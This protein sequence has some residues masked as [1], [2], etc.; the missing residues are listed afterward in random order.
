MNR[1]PDAPAFPVDDSELAGLVDLDDALRIEELDATARLAALLAGDRELTPESITADEAFHSAGA[2]RVLRAEA[3]RA[4]ERVPERALVLTDAAIAIV[5]AL[6]QYPPALTAMLRASAWRG[7]AD[8]LRY[9]GRYPE[10]LSALDEAEGAL[11]LVRARGFEEALITFVRATVLWKMGRLDEAMRLAQSATNTFRDYGDED[12][13]VKARILEGAILFDRGEY[14][15]ARG[16]YA[17]ILPAVQRMD[18]IGLSGTVMN[19]IGACEQEL[20]EHDAAARHFARALELFDAAT[21]SI[22]ATRTR[23]NLARLM[24]ARGQ[25]EDAVQLLHRVA[26]EFEASASRSDAALVLL[27]IAEILVDQSRHAESTLIAQSLVERFTSAGMLPSAVTALRYLHES[28]LARTATTAT[29]GHVREFLASLT[30]D[31]H[32]NFVGLAS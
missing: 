20:G 11:E 22:E 25:S 12:R 4:R 27:D 14:R 6:R 29:I 17:S 1:H 31:P 3:A 9:L 30:E 18:D 13:V 2:V 7:R 21:M 32:R 28:M 23:W 5:E 10:A 24:L 26:Q 16:V 8:A 15:D 19:D